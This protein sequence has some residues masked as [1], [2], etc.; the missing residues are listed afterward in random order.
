MVRIMTILMRTIMLDYFPSESGFMDEIQAA[1]SAAMALS[2]R[3]MPA[4]EQDSPIKTMG[5][6]MFDHMSQNLLLAKLKVDLH[7]SAKL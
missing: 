2:G 5:M 3:E 4:Q 7:F 6:C 1:T